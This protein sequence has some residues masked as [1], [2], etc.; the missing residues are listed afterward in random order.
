[1]KILFRIILFSTICL[2]GCK[3][4]KTTSTETESSEIEENLEET[5]NLPDEKKYEAIDEYYKEIDAQQPGLENTTKKVDEGKFSE[6]EIITY[7]KDSI[8]VKIIR[9]ETLASGS[10][11]TSYYIKD[12][13]L[14]FVHQRISNEQ[15]ADGPYIEEELSYYLYDGEVVKVLRKQE[16]F[17]TADQVKMDT[18]PN[19]DITDEMNEDKSQ[20]NEITETFRKTLQLI[21]GE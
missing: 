12:E 18:V 14:Y 2:I 3:E 9:K 21:E 17:A 20:I 5:K 13:D 4:N 19:N 7:R 15:S 6:T 1:M 16:E 8:P 10:V 11:N